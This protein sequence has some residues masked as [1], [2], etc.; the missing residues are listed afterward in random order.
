MF[1]LDT[2]YVVKCYLNEPGSSDVLEWIEGKTGLCCSLHG[3]LE[4]W[5]ALCRH[6]REARITDPEFRSVISSFRSDE[7]RAV[8]T[9]L[10]VTSVIVLAACDAIETIPQDSRIRSADALHLACAAENGFKWV[11]SHDRIMVASAPYFGLKGAD[12]IQTA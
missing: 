9:W 1:Y 2:S 10:D 3:R 11:F 5:S 8:W 12:I 7:Q 6:R 4:F